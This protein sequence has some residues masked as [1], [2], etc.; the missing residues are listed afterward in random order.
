MTQINLHEH[1]RA[2][3]I[4]EIWLHTRNADRRQDNGSSATFKPINFTG[5]SAI[6]YKPSTYNID[7]YP[8]RV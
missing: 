6:V 3:G 2:V 4:Q 8:C 7:W 1:E 5:S